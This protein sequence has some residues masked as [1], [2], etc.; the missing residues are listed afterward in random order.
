M[1]AAEIERWCEIVAALKART[2][3]KKGR[4]LSTSRVLELLAEHG[5]E[6]PAGLEQL[7][8][9]RITASTLMVLFSAAMWTRRFRM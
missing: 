2:A 1:S 5:V 8:K 4:C 3:N 7:P 9:G 6:T